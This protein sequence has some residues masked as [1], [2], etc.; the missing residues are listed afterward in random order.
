MKV[1]QDRTYCGAAVASLSVPWGEF[2][3]SRGGYHLVW[4][5][6]LVEAAGALIA[7]EAY[8]EAQDILRYLIATQQS[9]GHWFQNQWLGGSAFWPGIQLDEAGFPILLAAALREKGELAN[10]PVVD[11]IKRAAGF[12]VR[13]GPATQEDRWEE[14]A[15]VNLF[16]LAVA[17]AAL[18][19]ASAFLDGEA[20]SFALRLADYWNARI[21]SWTFVEDTPL[22]RQYGIRGYYIRT[23]PIGA[24][25][26]KDAQ[27]RA[28][29]IKNLMADP[30]LPANAQFATDFLQLVRYG[31]RAA[32]DPNILDSL[33]IIDAV[34]KTD[35]PS[36][37]VW[38]RYNDDGYGE[39]DDGS[40]FRRRWTRPRLAAADR[41]ARALGGC[42]RPER[43]ALHRGD[44]GDEQP[45]RADPRAGLGHRADRKIRPGARQ[46]ERLRDAAGLGARRVRQALLQP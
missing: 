15:G 27:S 31:L 9:D 35:T 11:A 43:A 2:S 44:D 28:V 37:P 16:T 17:I 38:H 25:A 22:A 26:N 1:H 41:R 30:D 4:P 36:G 39:H 12:I 33:K 19:E 13:E 14:D 23:L 45:A 24:Y 18:V 21:E 20:K 42:G 7:F 46:A 5:R 32:N 6:D 34:L 3:E 10:I 29:P 8:G 40:G